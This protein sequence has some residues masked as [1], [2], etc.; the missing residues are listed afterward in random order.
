MTDISSVTS[1]AAAMVAKQAA[2]LNKAAS[3]ATTSFADT[4]SRVGRAVG[5]KPRTGFPRTGFTAGPTYEA[6]TLAGQ[7]KAAFSHTLGATQAALGIKP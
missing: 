5:I 7:T 6:G 3:A 4:L 2:G 1:S